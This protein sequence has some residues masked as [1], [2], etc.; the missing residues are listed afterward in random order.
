MY[1]TILKSKVVTLATIGTYKTTRHHKE[2]YLGITY[3]TK[4]NRL[5]TLQMPLEGGLFYL[6]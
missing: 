2:T 5:I 3:H 4:K 1:D 6:V